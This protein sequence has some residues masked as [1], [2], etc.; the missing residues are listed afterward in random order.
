MPAWILAAI[1]VA[2]G[3]L[4]TVCTIALVVGP[5]I[6]PLWGQ[7]MD[8]LKRKKFVAA[9]KG[10]NDQLALLVNATSTDLDNR[11]ADVL[12]MVERELGKVKGKDAVKL[13]SI[14]RSVVAKSA[15]PV[16]AKSLLGSNIVG[17]IDLKARP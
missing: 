2:I 7:T 17:V 11:V 16:S 4:V 13:E 12:R 6:I 9:L 10:V 15:Q 1:P 14:A 3:A 8:E 5:F